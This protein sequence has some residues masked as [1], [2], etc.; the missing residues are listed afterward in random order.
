[1]SGVKRYELFGH[2]MMLQFLNVQNGVEPEVVS[3]ELSNA[4]RAI[5]VM[6]TDEIP[7]N[8]TEGLFVR[9]YSFMSLDGN[10]INFENTPMHV[11]GVKPEPSEYYTLSNDDV[12]VIDARYISCAYKDNP[13][14]MGM[15]KQ[16]EER[17]NVSISN[18][19][20][21]NGEKILDR[22]QRASPYSFALEM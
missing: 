8:P 20:H 4:C 2:Y 7:A 6:V 13:K 17:Y 16:V 10:K 15:I 9:G 11:M 18:E 1:M 14:I 12:T 3:P 22:P 5:K 21:L 19:T